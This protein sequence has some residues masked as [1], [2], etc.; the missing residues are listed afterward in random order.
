MKPLD[1]TALTSAGRKRPLDPFR[2]AV[3]RGLAILLPP[4]LT[5]VIFIW[6]GSTVNTNLLA[7]LENSARWVLVQELSDI[8]TL[9]GPE[10]P[11]NVGAPITIDGKDY[12][13]A[14]DGHFVPRSVYEYV[15]ETLGKDPMPTTA[16]DIYT[17]YVDHKWLPR[18]YVVP[19]F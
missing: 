4:L 12:I 1:P 2:R 3:L 18:R 5:I 19:L 15:E 14:S 13:R 7:P 9:S 8:R 17:R 11:Q 6:I 10:V 16:K